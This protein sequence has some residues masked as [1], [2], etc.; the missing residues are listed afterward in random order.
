MHRHDIE[1]TI[2]LYL[3]T[4]THYT[5]TRKNLLTCLFTLLLPIKGVFARSAARPVL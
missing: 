3:L 4:C 2:I 1:S 5:S